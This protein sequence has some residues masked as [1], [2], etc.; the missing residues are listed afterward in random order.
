M[1]RRPRQHPLVRSLFLM[2]AV[3]A[4]LATVASPAA[5]A[6]PAK[7]S[8]GRILPHVGPSRS[9][10]L[11]VPSGTLG[12]KSDLGWVYDDD[13]IAVVGEV[14]NNTAMRQKAIRVRVT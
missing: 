12:F 5:A 7:R 1:T 8:G 6:D 2:L 4:L 3:A 9:T 14:Q 11:V 13:S 10:A